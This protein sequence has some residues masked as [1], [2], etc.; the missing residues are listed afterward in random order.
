MTRVA[1]VRRI[2]RAHGLRWASLTAL[3]LLLNDTLWTGH[4]LLGGVLAALACAAYARVQPPGATGAAPGGVRR[5]RAAIVLAA[6][7]L[8]DIAR[9]NVAV[10]RIVLGVHP[11]EQRSDFVEIPLELRDPRGLAV[12]AC[13]VTATPGTAWARHEPTAQVLTLHVLDLVDPQAWVRTIKDRY[14]TLLLEIFR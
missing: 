4:L 1:V 12:L 6:R 10:A 8:V 3:W 7:V 14:E 9:S 5:V 2:V 11:R 13:I